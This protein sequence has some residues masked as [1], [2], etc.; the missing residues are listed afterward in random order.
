[1][2]NRLEDF[3]DF[4]WDERLPDETH[5]EFCARRKQEQAIIDGHLK[6]TPLDDDEIG[7]QRKRY[8]KKKKEQK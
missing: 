4:G 6:G 8:N 3:D 1:M 2:S 7:S 5:E